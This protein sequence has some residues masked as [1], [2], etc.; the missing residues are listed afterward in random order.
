[1]LGVPVS[2]RTMAPAGLFNGLPVTYTSA[3]FES[4]VVETDGSL[5]IDVPATIAAIQRVYCD[6]QHII[7]RE[8][9]FIQANGIEKIVADVPYLAG[10]IAA[11]AGVP[12]IGIGNFTWEWIYQPYL[13]TVPG[14]ELLREMMRST[15]NKMAT[16]C[17]LPFHHEEGFEIFRNLQDVPLVVRQPKKTRD[18]VLHALGLPEKDSRPKVLV[19]MR[20]RLA[21]GALQTAAMASSDLLFLYLDDQETV[22]APN[23]KSVQ[24]GHYGITYPDLLGASDIVVSKYGYGI[25]SDCAANRKPMLVPPRTD[26]REDEVFRR[27]ASQYIPI[28][29]ISRTDF[30]SGNWREHLQ[31]VASARHSGKHLQTNGAAICAELIIKT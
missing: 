13:E 15:Y 18:E 11:A 12:C 16:F 9:Q 2:V 1:M 21:A 23:A 14:T 30:H 17:R 8:L 27:Q 7:A 3:N 19:G 20:G 22:D 31:T 24:L 29:A 25:V 5:A 28:A 26:F 6:R 10:D 4:G